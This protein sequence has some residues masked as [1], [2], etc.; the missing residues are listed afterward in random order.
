MEKLNVKAAVVSGA[1]TSGVLHALFGMVY[2]GAPQMMSG[3]YNM[4]MYN[5]IQFGNGYFSA[6]NWMGSIITG[7]IFGAVLGYLIA[8]SYNWGLDK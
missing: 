5:S 1:I 2:L 8:I 4:M 6:T 3:V 7:A